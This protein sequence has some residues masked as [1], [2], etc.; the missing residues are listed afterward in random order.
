MT[1][2]VGCFQLQLELQGF[3]RGQWLHQLKNLLQHHGKLEA[4]QGDL[5]LPRLD[6]G[7]IKQGVD[8]FEQFA[9][10]LEDTRQPIPLVVRERIVRICIEQGFRKTVDRVQRSPQLVGH[11]CEKVA[12]RLCG[13]FQ[14][15]VGGLKLACALPDF[16]HELLE[17]A[18][19]VTHFVPAF[20]NNRLSVVL[21]PDGANP[22]PQVLKW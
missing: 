2:P 19:Q 7:E 15:S 1:L 13:R 14:F 6:F 3:W 21:L 9:S 20:H 18:G 16:H 11:A 8:Q 12:L 10:A 22:I 5:H 17:L 4:L